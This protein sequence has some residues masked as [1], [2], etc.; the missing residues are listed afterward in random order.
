MSVHP[1][2]VPAIELSGSGDDD[3]ELH[4]VCCCKDE[5]LALCGRD[6]TGYPDVP[7]LGESGVVADPEDCLVCAELD[8]VEDIAM[9]LSLGAQCLS[10]RNAQGMSCLG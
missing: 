9:H 1:I 2:A 4:H 8:A 3:V 6:L 10:L 5:D 7:S